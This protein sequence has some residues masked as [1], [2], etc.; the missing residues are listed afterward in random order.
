MQRI[1]H[2]KP[3]AAPLPKPRRVAGYSRV[4]CGKDAMLHSLSA[5]VSYYSQLIQRTHGWIYAGVYAD[6]AI[7][8]TKCE[9]PEFQRLLED[10]RAGKI[11]LILTKSVSR[12]ARNTITTLET[13]RELRALG[14]DVFFEEENINTLDS[15]GELLITIMGN[16]LLLCQEVVH[17]VL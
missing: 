10:C 11:D 13:I 1:I 12:F 4:S 2:K 6:E 8:G 14:V 9:R 3:I 15:K 16:A 5:Q 17:L 7:T